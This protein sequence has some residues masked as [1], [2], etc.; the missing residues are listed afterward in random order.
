ML[1]LLAFL[2]QN[3]LVIFLVAIGASLFAR[4]AIGKGDHGNARIAGRIAFGASGIMLFIHLVSFAFGFSLVALVMSGLWGY[5]TY[6]SWQ[7]LQT[8]R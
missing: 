5:W 2:M 1:D 8:L 7:F 3:S 4:S 6:Q